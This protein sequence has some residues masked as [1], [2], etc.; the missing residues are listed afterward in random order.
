M[1]N[2]LTLSKNIFEHLEQITIDDSY[3]YYKPNLNVSSLLIEQF[4]QAIDVEN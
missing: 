4:R 1:A 2:I 3:I